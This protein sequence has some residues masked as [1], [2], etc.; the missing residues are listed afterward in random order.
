MSKVQHKVTSRCTAS[1]ASDA[2]HGV[3]W[4]Q[5][6]PIGSDLS[7]DADGVFPSYYVALI[8]LSHM[9][10]LTLGKQMP[11][12]A[13]YR[14]TGLKIGL[15]NVDDADDNDRGA[16]FNGYVYWHGATKHKVDAIQVMRLLENNSE[17]DQIDSDSL[18]LSGAK[19]YRG[20]RY[21]WDDDN[22]V[23]YQ[24]DAMDVSGWGSAT[25]K[26]D[27]NLSSL[28]DIYS[29]SVDGTPPGRAL[30]DTRVGKA[31]KMRFA[32]GYN[33]AMHNDP[34]PSVGEPL[35]LPF[36][37]ENPDVHDFDWQA[38][39]DRHIDVLGGMIAVEF[40][41]GNTLPNGDASPDDYD[42]VMEITI[43]GWSRF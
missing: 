10:S 20:I 21:G 23:F 43:E 24:T 12:D 35:G 1:S 26:T 9:L 42:I 16:V 4:I 2:Y 27:W 13:V 34:W 32:V 3:G 15:Q 11:M 31:N 17:E 19:Q 7:P 36:L 38:Q 37:I 6:S 39:D 29:D 40:R 25:G 30:W 33:N 5:P 8:D 22:Q 14:V 28:F 41:G 18:F